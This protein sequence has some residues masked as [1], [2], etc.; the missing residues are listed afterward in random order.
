MWA[1][2]Y[3][4][5]WGTTKINPNKKQIQRWQILINYVRNN[6]LNIVLYP[7]RLPSAK[8]IE[9]F[10]TMYNRLLSLI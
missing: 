2:Q 8:G 1:A 5:V 9:F 4:Q 3:I 10:K 7:L 6:T